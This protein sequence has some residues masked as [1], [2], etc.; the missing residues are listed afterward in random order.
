MNKENVVY[1]C[2]GLLFSHTKERNL[3]TCDNMAEA[4]GYYANEARHKRTNNT[5]YH[6]YDKI[7]TL[8]EAESRAVVSNGW[9]EEEK[10]RY[11]VQGYK[12]SVMQMNET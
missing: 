1:K 3:A 6:L 4:R 2:N 8:I 12:V 5:W 7:V 10:K 9:G 11:L